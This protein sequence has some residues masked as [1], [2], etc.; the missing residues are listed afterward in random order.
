MGDLVQE[1]DQQITKYVNV[2][3]FL[4]NYISSPDRRKLFETLFREIE[5]VI[6]GIM[7]MDIDCSYHIRG[8]LNGL[9]LE[10]SKRIT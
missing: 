4:R 7:D 5:G 1:E 9:Q 8:L 3:N 2:T 10:V 6:I